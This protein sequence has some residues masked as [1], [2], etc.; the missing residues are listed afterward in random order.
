MQSSQQRVCNRQVFR[1]DQ[2]LVYQL[3]RTIAG[4]A[5]MAPRALTGELAGTLA[6]AN[7]DRDRKGYS[8]KVIDVKVSTRLTCSSPLSLEVSK[9]GILSLEVDI[10]KMPSTTLLVTAKL[11]FSSK[12]RLDVTID[13]V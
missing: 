9:T 12:G 5:N 1:Y 2:Q 7:R 4:Y 13:I 6:F 8:T 10:S 11:T 3:D